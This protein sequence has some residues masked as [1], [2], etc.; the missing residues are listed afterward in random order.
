MVEQSGF[1]R[2][3]RAPRG[4]QQSVVVVEDEPD[5]LEVLS[6]N[7]R[8]EGFEVETSNDGEE[9]LKLIQQHRPD[10]VLLDLMLP[11]MDGLDICRTIKSD[12]N[13]G[14]IPVIMVTA[15]SA[16]S[17]LVLGLGIGADDYVTKPFSPKELVARVKA[18]LRRGRVDEQIDTK[19]RIDIDGL[20]LEADKHK[21]VLNGE[22]VKLTPT[23]FRLLH[24]LASNPG[25]VFTRKQLLPKAFGEGVVVV[26]RNVD[27]HIRS[28]R[29]KV[30]PKQAFVETIRGVGYRFKEID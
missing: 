4:P 29:K 13:T 15:K 28:I 10:L 12:Q 17:D 5:I 24:F 23:E 8:R 27:V 16:E 18:V 21:V 22:E 26:D 30:D 7:L 9:G 25:R 11:N 2:A 6:Y 20:V 3:E 14:H 1:Q 19:T